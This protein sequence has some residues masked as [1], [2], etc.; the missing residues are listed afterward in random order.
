M[1]RETLRRAAKKNKSVSR[2][3]DYKTLR[4]VS[5]DANGRILLSVQRTDESDIEEEVAADFE[6]LDKTEATY[7]FAGPRAE[8][9]TEIETIVS[10]ENVSTKV[11]L[12][13]NTF[14]KLTL[15]K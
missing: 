13:G 6:D 10:T 1:S 12:F 14:Y 5:V 9:V 2:S 15:E 7:L 4:I 11:Y 8:D 3:Y